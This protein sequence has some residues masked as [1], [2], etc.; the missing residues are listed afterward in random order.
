MYLCIMC[1]EA[2]TLLTGIWQFASSNLG[3]V[4]L[5]RLYHYLTLNHDGVQI[6]Y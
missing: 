4:R 2:V 1:V 6:I 5:F 3:W